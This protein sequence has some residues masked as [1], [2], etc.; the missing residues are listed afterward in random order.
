MEDRRQ[1]SRFYSSL[2]ARLT[3]SFHPRF[4][5]NSGV[6]F[7]VVPLLSPALAQR[8]SSMKHNP[9]PFPP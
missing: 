6:F 2:K 7:C 5:L 8:T 3:T 1:Q 9:M 4:F